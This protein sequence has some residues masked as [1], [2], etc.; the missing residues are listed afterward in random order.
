[1]AS[2]IAQPILRDAKEPQ[3]HVLRQ[4]IGNVAGVGLQSNRTVRE[5]LA[6]AF[7]GIDQSEVLED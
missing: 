7:Q 3:R 2:N 4:C 6:L 5:A 1:M